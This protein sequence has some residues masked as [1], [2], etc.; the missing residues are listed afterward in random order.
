MNYKTKV[1]KSLEWRFC[2]PDPEIE[3]Y[4]KNKITEPKP[5]YDLFLPFFKSLTQEI[6]IVVCLNSMNK[7]IAYETISKGGLGTSIVHPREVFRIAIVSNCKSIIL[8][9]NHPSG[10]LNPS[11]EDK[12][13]TETIRNSGNI[14]GIPLL[15]HLIIT[16]EGYYSFE[17]EARM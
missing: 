4:R 6:A 16:D 9:H 15:D 13:I 12:A 14:I 8:M 11:K 3:K 17:K 1:I 5:L 2:E 7:I 10:N